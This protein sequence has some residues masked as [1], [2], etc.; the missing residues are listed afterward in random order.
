MPNSDDISM[1]DELEPV[2]FKED[3]QV[4]EQSKFSKN[5]DIEDENE[6]DEDE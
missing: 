1:S 6:S 5:E 2:L 3:N 4:K